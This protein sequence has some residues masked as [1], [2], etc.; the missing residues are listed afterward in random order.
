MKARWILCIVI[1]AATCSG[2]FAFGQ[3]Y[4]DD[5]D[6]KHK[7]KDKDKHKYKKE[8]FKEKDRETEVVF[9]DHDRVVMR[10]WY[11]DRKGK[12]K[13]PPGLAKKD[14]LPPGLERQL[15]IRGELTP[16]LRERIQ[17]CP[18]ELEE[19]LPP[20]PP[21]YAHVI[22]GGHIVLLNR[23]TSIVMDILHLEL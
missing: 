9:V 17:P 2:P 22:I 5:Q 18:E 19:R 7:D 23:R 6:Y 4:G 20:P 1:L 10:E 11:V 13:L 12:G 14:R 15:V 8:K 16:D 21:D 3:G